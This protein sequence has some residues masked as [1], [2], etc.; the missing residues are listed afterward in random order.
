MKPETSS[1]LDVVEEELEANETESLEDDDWKVD[2]ELDDG[3][4][5]D[6]GGLGL[7]LHKTWY[8]IV[9]VEQ[10]ITRNQVKAGSNNTLTNG[11]AKNV[12]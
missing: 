4:L 1:P 11:S 8:Q 7:H 12:H 2:D 9:D 3:E 10:R 6:E 5:V